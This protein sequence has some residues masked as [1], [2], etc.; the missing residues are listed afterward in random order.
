MADDI[1]FG[2]WLEE[3]WP[4]GAGI[5]FGLGC[6]EREAATN[7]GVDAGLVVVVKRAAER[8]LSAFAASDAILLCGQL[9]FPFFVGFDH[10]WN[11]GDGAD[12][13]FVVEKS[14]LDHS[15]FICFGVGRISGKTLH[16]T[17]E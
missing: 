15:L 11:G 12:V 4:T 8:W 5:E 14:Y 1:F 10:L 17:G 7:A 16:G 13:A 9:L 6:E 3:A 2:D